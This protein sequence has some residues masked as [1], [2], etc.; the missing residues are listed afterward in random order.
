MKKY[1][2]TVL[3]GLAVAL[4][5]SAQHYRN[6]R[7]YN[8]GTGRLDYSRNASFGTYHG[9]YA[10]R[11]FYVGFRVGPSFGT[12]NSD[13]TYLDGSSMKTG[14]NVGIAAGFGLTPRAPLFLETGLYYTEKGGKNTKNGY[15]FKYNL[16]YLEVPFVLK[17]V[18]N[19]DRTFSLQ[20]FFGGYL[21]GGVG[22]KIK[23]FND[24][25]AYSSFGDKYDAAFKRFDGGLR[26]G[27]GVGIDMFY[28]DLTYDLGL[29]NVGQDDFDE[30]KTSTLM[31]NVGV[32]F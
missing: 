21:A 19:I 9:S 28:A 4:P 18:Y 29:A 22:G 17:Y 3:M 12:V 20:P 32:N 16:N 25:E 10:Q 11:P 6:S 30:T 24:R 23:N 2:V 7:Y 27:V 15:D 1:L 13:A 5:S 31:L 26:M 8:P 14:L